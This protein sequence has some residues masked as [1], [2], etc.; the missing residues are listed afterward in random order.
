MQ[1]KAEAQIKTSSEFN[2]ILFPY[3]MIPN[4][5]FHFKNLLQWKSSFVLLI[6]SCS[7]FY[8]LYKIIDQ[9]FLNSSHL[10][11]ENQELERAGSKL[12]TWVDPMLLV[13]IFGPLRLVW[14]GKLTRE[15]VSRALSD[16]KGGRLLC[17]NSFA[18]N[19]KLYF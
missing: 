18:Y 12:N 3:G 4:C 8:I 1:I 19:L 5:V 9:I 15:H 14:G 11:S 10:G 17:V 13:V 16:G 6:C 7:I 2:H